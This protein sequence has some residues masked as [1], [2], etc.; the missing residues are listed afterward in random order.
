MGLSLVRLYALYV[1]ACGCSQA[2]RNFF[3]RSPCTKMH[4]DKDA[5]GT[6]LLSTFSVKVA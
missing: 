1:G 6:V 5:K 4:L 3:A 2:A